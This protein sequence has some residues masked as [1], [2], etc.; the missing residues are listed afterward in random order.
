MITL[1]KFIEVHNGKYVDWDGKYGAQCVDLIRFYLKEVFAI[2]PYAIPAVN[3]AK[4]IYTKFNPA[5]KFFT[6]IYNSATAVPQKGD[7]IVWGW[8]W[9]TT[10]YAGHVA[11][12]T[13]GDVNRFISF[14]QNYPSGSTCRYYNHSYSGVLGWLHRK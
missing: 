11:I 12:C 3:Y 6:R 8:S 2:D 4:E 14:D 7:I 10:G 13:G 1:D 9:P 5:N